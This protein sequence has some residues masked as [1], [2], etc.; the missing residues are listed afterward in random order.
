MAAGTFLTLSIR[1]AVSGNQ[2]RFRSNDSEGTFECFAARINPGLL[3][4]SRK[5]SGPNEIRQPAFLTDFSDRQDI[6]TGS[7]VIRGWASSS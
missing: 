6:L 5:E 1:K 2:Q 7:D 3:S 4:R